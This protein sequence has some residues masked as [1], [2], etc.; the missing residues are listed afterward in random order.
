MAE[1]ESKT[2]IVQKQI[3]VGKLLMQYGQSQIQLVAAEE[4]LNQARGIIQMLQN[5][6]TQLRTQLAKNSGAATDGD[7]KQA[8][9][10][11]IPTPA[12]S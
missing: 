7:G 5:E 6:V 8:G 2:Q 9:P 1:Q 3:P 12:A 11:L 4:E 10:E